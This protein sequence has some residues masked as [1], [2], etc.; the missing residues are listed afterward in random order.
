[1]SVLKP[2]HLNKLGVRRVLSYETLSSTDAMPPLMARSF[3]PNV[4]CDITPYIERKLEI[5]SLYPTEV[6]PYPL[7]R[8]L[9]SIRA[10]ARLRGSTVGVEYA[11]S[12]MLLREVS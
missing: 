2:F 6:Q 11:E 1:M 12:F 9:E 10:L 8:A 4:F 5:M 7:P 3:V